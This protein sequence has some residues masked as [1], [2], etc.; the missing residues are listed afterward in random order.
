MTITKTQLA[1]NPPGRTRRCGCSP[2]ATRPAPSRWAS[3]LFL[4]AS[5]YSFI[6]TSASP[7]VS[8]AVGSS[9]ANGTPRTTTRYDR[10]RQNLDLHPNY[11][12]AAYMA[13]GT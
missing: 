8:T 6:A 3:T 13:S 11:I 10:A 5:P 9:Y 4:P 2:P 12:L 1:R 7:A